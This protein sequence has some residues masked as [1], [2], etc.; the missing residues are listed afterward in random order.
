MAGM[1]TSDGM[2][3]DPQAHEEHDDARDDAQREDERP[4]RQAKDED[5]PGATIDDA[6]PA[7]PNEPG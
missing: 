5:S 7:E 2:T 1:G 4:D 6:E 3:P